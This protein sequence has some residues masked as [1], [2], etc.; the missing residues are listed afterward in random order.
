MIGKAR[1][2][3]LRLSVALVGGASIAAALA[4]EAS[5]A[6]RRVDAADRAFGLVLPDPY[7][8]MEGENNAELQDWLKAQGAST[9]A[10]LDAAPAL[11]GWQKRLQAASAATTINRLQRRV[12]GR[13][14][15]LRIEGEGQAVLMVRDTDGK[16]RTLLDPNPLSTKDSPASIT[17]YSIS[18]DARRVAV[19]VDHGGSEVTTISIVDVD[20][21][22]ALPDAIGAVW[23]EFTASWLPDGSGFIYTQMASAEPKPGVDP[24]LDMHAAIHRLGEPASND[25]ILLAAGTNARFPLKPEEFPGIDASAASDWAVA[26]AG[27]ARPETRLCVAPVA[28]ALKPGAA[29]NCL[30]GYADGVT[31]YALD[32]NTLYLQSTHGAPNG[33]ILVLDLS[34]P[35]PRLADARTLLPE[36]RR[37]VLTNLVLARD[38]LYVR[39]MT[40]GIDDIVRLPKGGRAAQPIAMPFAGAAFQMWA[41]PRSD[42]VVFTLQSW[43]RPRALYAYDA[44]SGSIADLHL[45]ATSPRDYGD[46]ETLETEATSAD[47]T[48]VPLSIVYPKNLKRDGQALAILDGYGSYG[49][50][51][52][53]YFD[54]MLLEWVRAGH[55]YAVAHV[56]G[57][58]EKGRAWWQA[59]KGAN[60]YKSVDDFLACARR[61]A[62]LGYTAP[63][64]LA[65][66]GAS[67]GGLLI[68]G[69]IT[70]A[71]GAFGAAVIHAG[72]L[73]PV[74]L[75]SG[76]NGANQIAEIGDPRTAAG[77]K[78]IAAMDPYQRVRDGT[79]YPA[80]M[81]AVGLNDKRVA[82]WESAKFG[83]R[84]AAATASGRPVWFRTSG[85]QGHF[86]G[87]LSAEAGEAADSYTFFEME[88]GTRR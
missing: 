68:G 48:R 4:A 80:L 8:W 66:T 32:G 83:A 38:G 84:V 78:A 46:I 21:G 30:A 41:D 62:A 13:L 14:F 85:D 73:N 27:G 10:R 88:L 58:G 75:L 29:W 82:P 69:A 7:R 55:V 37:A 20:S 64:R 40:D 2:L 33:K 17:E 44:A 45:G 6:A 34:R 86:S 1:S 52:Q 3:A 26:V 39:R 36:S 57:G 19:D 15:F 25:Q 49:D 18:A 11:A 9:R 51:I 74:R 76:S 54:P 24:M 43:T 87:N 60:K 61:L 31:G 53:P 35:H 79:R 47:G 71:P 5:P 81:L 42:G 70:K 65:A 23:G 22:K 28:E 59:G 72:M 77:L 50:S 56:R 12:A 67:A 16:E 63:E